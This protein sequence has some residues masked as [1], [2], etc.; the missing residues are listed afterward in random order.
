MFVMVFLFDFLF[1]FSL[2]CVFGTNPPAL[3]FAG[4]CVQ[5]WFLSFHTHTHTLVMKKKINKINT[6]FN[7][8][9]SRV[10]PQKDLIFRDGGNIIY[11]FTNF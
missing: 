8:L 2:C 7:F 4:S 10:F 1:W 9:I 3:C 6:T 11:H 5:F